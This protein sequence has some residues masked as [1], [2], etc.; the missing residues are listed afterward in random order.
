MTTNAPKQSI[1]RESESFYT[2]TL[3]VLL[4]LVVD[5]CTIL[6]I[7]KGYLQHDV[8]DSADTAGSNQLMY[9]VYRCTVAAHI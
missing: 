1:L 2:H 7:I 8:Q 5:T 6:Y 3:I 9:T 4:F